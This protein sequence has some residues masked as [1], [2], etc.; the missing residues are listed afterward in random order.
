MHFSSI[1]FFLFFASLL[2]AYSFCPAR[3]RQALLLTSSLLWYASFDVSWILPLVS[4]AYLSYQLTARGI[5]GGRN[6]TA[7]FL[8]SI[9]SSLAI[10]FAYRWYG[11]GVSDFFAQL[12]DSGTAAINSDQIWQEP[13]VPLG[14]NFV[15]FLLIS[16]T[17]DVWRGH[18]SISRSFSE[19]LL[20]VF[21]F[22]K[23]ANGPLEKHAHFS[24]QLKH[25]GPLKAENLRV[26]LT[27]FIWGLFKK[28]Y[29]ADAVIHP[30]RAVVVSPEAGL[31]PL[32][33]AGLLS[34]FQVY[35]EFSGYC[36]IGRGAAGCLGIKLSLN[37]RPF[38]LARSPQDFW[39]R[40]N[41]SLGNWVRD[42]ALFPLLFRFGRKISASLIIALCFLLVGFWHGSTASWIL[43]GLMHGISMAAYLFL[44]K[45][46]PRAGAALGLTLLIPLY[47]LS[48]LLHW[49]SQTNGLGLIAALA[50]H[51][52]GSA[53]TLTMMLR[54][55]LPY[56]LPMM[57][58]EYVWLEKK[59][60]NFFHE[61]LP[62]QR[63]IF[64]SSCVAILLLFNRSSVNPFTY[65]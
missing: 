37:F 45:H 65:L 19:F 14:L 13:T 63:W 1:S 4:C 32:L 47:C 43:F 38:Y 54:H 3:F 36:D 56:I 26:G 22:P 5:A 11:A 64:V 24:D 6:G 18:S 9:S 44:R 51:E 60:D 39:Q 48:G 58:V 27:L 42:Y 55:S 52:P 30:V 17:V 10:L 57:A 31:L 50:T 8:T 15:A 28:F 62:L 46:S 25:L 20:F 35:A 16:Y 61:L 49:A 53:L 7:Y 33:L 29:V 23:L 59:G 34:T 2:C 40:W 12:S 41:I 21:F